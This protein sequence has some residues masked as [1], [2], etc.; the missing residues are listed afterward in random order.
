[1]EDNSVDSI[2]MALKYR[3]RL[4]FGEAPEVYSGV[5][6]CRSKPHR[7]PFKWRHAP[8]H[9]VEGNTVTAVLVSADREHWF[10]CRHFP[11]LDEAR[12]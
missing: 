4:T 3:K 5:G 12:P 7:L 8:A 10:T 2:L 6:G 9:R 11:K 1:M